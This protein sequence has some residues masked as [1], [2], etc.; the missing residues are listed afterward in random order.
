[1]SF[2][3]DQQLMYTDMHGYSSK[4]I[5]MRYSQDGSC[6]VVSVPPSTD[7]TYASLDR[8]TPLPTP[9]ELRGDC[10]DAIIQSAL[11]APA[12]PVDSKERKRYPMYSGLL[13]YF[14]AALAQVSHHSFVSNEK[15]NP[16]LPLQH[17]RNNSGDHSDCIVRHLL[18][19]AEATGATKIEELRALAWR[20]LAMLQEEC[21]KQGARPAPG[22]TFE[23]QE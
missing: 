23:E 16:G 12:L 3:K 22:A 13:A 18:D 21:E 9:Q 19:S 20:A 14:P 7:R 15:H 4:V 2:V 6:A 17:S 10:V 1:M 8:L 11:K 5:F